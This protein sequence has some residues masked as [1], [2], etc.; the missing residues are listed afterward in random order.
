M[1]TILLK[2][3]LMTVTR[4]TGTDVIERLKL[5]VIIA[6]DQNMTGEQKRAQV[7]ETW[8]G[9]ASEIRRDIGT[10]LVDIARAVLVAWLRHQRVID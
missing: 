4:L 6:A 9:L 10:N 1:K 3:L 7:L 8:K 2:I 5:M